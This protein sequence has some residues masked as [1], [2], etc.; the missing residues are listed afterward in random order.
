LF[1]HLLKF[2][3][4]HKD[5]VVTGKVAGVIEPHAGNFSVIIITETG[6]GGGVV[7]VLAVLV[8]LKQMRKK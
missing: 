1:L 3:G 6:N 4:I 2:V 8:F 5:P 7:G